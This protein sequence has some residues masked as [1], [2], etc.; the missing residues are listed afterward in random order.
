MLNTP[1]KQ[2]VKIGILEVS[3]QNRALL[4]FYFSAT[5]KGYFKAV[6]PDQAS[7]FIIDYDSPGAK[8]SWK[9][10]FN[11][12]QKPG[13]LISI[14]KVEL[15]STIWV[16]KPL[17]SKAL[18]D[19]SEAIKEMIVIEE[20]AV[21][22]F[23]KEVNN[24]KAATAIAPPKNTIEK[25]TVKKRTVE[26]LPMSKQKE[27]EAA[28]LDEIIL[29]ALA[30]EPTADVIIDKPK[31]I[32][33]KSKIKKE[34]TQNPP[35]L[36]MAEASATISEKITASPELIK[37]DSNLK[38][39]NAVLNDAKPIEV[40]E[41]NS[42]VD[43]LL[44]SLES[45]N[46]GIE[47]EAIEIMPE[48]TPL[49]VQNNIEDLDNPK[50]A[51]VV[52]N[53]TDDIKNEEQVNTPPASETT[54]DSPKSASRKTAEEELKFLLDE[55]KNEAGGPISGLDTSTNK[56]HLPIQSDDRWKLAYGENEES[57][58]LKSLCT[59][60]SSKHILTNL[61]ENIKKAK[62]TKTVSRIKFNNI[63]VV[64]DPET[65]NVYCDESIFSKYYADIC[66]NPTQ[67]NEIKT[68]NLDASEIRLYR[69]KIKTGSDR[70]HSIESFLWT[71]SLVTHQGYLP[72]DTD[73][74]KKLHLETWPNLTRLE[75]IP[76][77][78]QIAAIFQKRSKSLSEIA[79]ELE[80]SNK[81][82]ISFYNAALALGFITSASNP[83]FVA[84][85]ADSNNKENKYRGFFSRL[86][87]RLRK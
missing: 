57:D 80:I 87:K 31:R 45:E 46:A 15:P 5:G 37:T 52:D 77:S 33:S 64:V 79:N 73:L 17:T 54:A 25:K 27:R 23:T 82:I 50:E 75:N 85:P 47:L 16:A 14:T 7:C 13:I 55:I 56:N 70:I 58:S 8:N 38:T 41:S 63:I 10:I 49:D 51:M 26:D 78:I 24:N 34:L 20:P 21:M 28:E 9:T 68:H 12:T 1:N 6:K 69:N 43:N 65:D 74:N 84:S 83:L 62:E 66:H 4:E 11:K 48:D 29:N 59:I 81:Y 60:E 3:A 32:T 67:N 61:L 36:A 30:E 76:H 2:P 39:A 18:T 19:A 44:K 72:I 42:E 35:K 22:D 53:A 86:L 71:T 40:S